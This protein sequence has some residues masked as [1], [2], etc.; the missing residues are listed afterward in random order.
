MIAEESANCVFLLEEAV[1]INEG[2]EGLAAMVSSKLE[3][4]PVWV[5]TFV[6]SMRPQKVQDSIINVSGL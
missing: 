5:H 4:D 2:F 3:A 6:L 1:H